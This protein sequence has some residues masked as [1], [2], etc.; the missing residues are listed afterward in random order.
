MNRKDYMGV[1]VVNHYVSP[2]AV[3]CFGSQTPA[4]TITEIA[5]FAGGYD[6]KGSIVKGEQ[7]AKIRMSDLQFG[8]LIARPNSHGH[9]TTLE[10]LH[11]YRVNEGHLQNNPDERRLKNLIK[12]S[13]SKD[14]QISR[15]IRE[16]EEIAHESKE[17]KRLV[18][19][20]ELIHLLSLISSNAPANFKFHFQQVGE[21]GAKRVIEAKSQIHS[22]IRNA[23]R[24][25]TQPLAIEDKTATNTEVFSC[26]ANAQVM[27]RS[28]HTRLFDTVGDTFESLSFEILAENE[29]DVMKRVALMENEDSESRSDRLYISRRVAEVHLSLDQYA[30]FVR[31]D[32][33]EVPCTISRVGSY[34]AHDKVDAD[35]RESLMGNLKKDAREILSDLLSAASEAATIIDHNG[36]RSASERN[37]LIDIC[38]SLASIYERT[39][40]QIEDH[41]QKV[42]QNVLSAYQDEI[43]QYQEEELEKLPA[44]ERGAMKRLI[45]GN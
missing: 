39:E 45:E 27:H 21:V 35:H 43:N 14:N 24:M 32:N 7:L 26:F 17:K 31:A 42:A 6:E 28:G 20:K 12:S 18:R 29:E 37:K 1:M 2:T 44:P 16:V 9:P 15:F 23:Y 30:R 4:K 38:L 8:R 13:G 11:G 25:K 5:I 33:T 22:L 41:S 40:S 3:S 34:I 19:K 36:A 10:L